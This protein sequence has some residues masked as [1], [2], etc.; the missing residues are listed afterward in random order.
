MGSEQREAQA[1][2]LI[3]PQV[4]QRTWSLAQV[5]SLQ[6]AQRTAQVTQSG[7]WSIWQ[8]RVWVGQLERPQEEQVRAQATQ[9]ERFE[10]AQRIR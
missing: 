7:V 1:V 6:R 10:T 9:T 8:A 5:T 3:S 4:R 2:Q